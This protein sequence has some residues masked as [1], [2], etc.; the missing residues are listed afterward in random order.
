MAGQRLT[1]KGTYGTTPIDWA[2]LLMGVDISDTT[3]SDDG[4]SKSLKAQRLITTVTSSLDNAA[5]QALNVTPLDLFNPGAGFIV[6]PIAVTIVTTYASATE[7]SNFNMYLGYTSGQ[8]LVYWDY[9]SRF[10]GSI[11]TSSSW[12]F[13]GGNSQAKGVCTTSISGLPL[14][15]WSSGAFNG[16]WTCDV[17]ATVSV[18][19]AI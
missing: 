2:D 12:V 3:S 13:S 16:G 4:T 10:M 11:T 19:P 5:V 17:Y 1:D 6:I 7:S 15:M 18:F 9:V 14:K 8:T